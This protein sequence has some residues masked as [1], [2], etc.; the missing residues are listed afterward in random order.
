MTYPE[1]LRRNG[2]PDTLCN[3]VFYAESQELVKAFMQD[4]RLARA[5]QFFKSFKEDNNNETI[6]DCGRAQ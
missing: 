3:R 6:R 4:I 1:F 5:V 2:L